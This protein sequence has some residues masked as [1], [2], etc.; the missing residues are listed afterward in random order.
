MPH[1]RSHIGNNVNKDYGKIYWDF[2]AKD[3]D[4][5]DSRFEECTFRTV[6]ISPALVPGQVSSQAHHGATE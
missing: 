2:L 5:E 3:N 4:L 1:V 6:A